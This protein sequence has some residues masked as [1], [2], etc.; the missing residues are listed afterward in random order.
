[1]AAA[2]IWILIMHWIDL[3]WL[4]LPGWSGAKGG[5]SFSWYDLTTVIGIGGIY[6]W[7]FWVK[8]ISSAIVPSGDPQLKASIEHINA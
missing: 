1:M 6:F 7:V 8:L 5:A 4:V 3:Y 2:A